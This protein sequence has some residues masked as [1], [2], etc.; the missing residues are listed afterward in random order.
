MTTENA[1]INKL[2][3]LNEIIDNASTLPPEC[4][5]L[6]LAIAKSMA[7]TKNGMLKEAEEAVCENNI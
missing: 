7:F 3:T 6:L 1:D 2:K 4:Q 5:D